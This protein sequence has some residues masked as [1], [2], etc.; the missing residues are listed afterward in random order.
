MAF[1]LHRCWVVWVG[2]DVPGTPPGPSS[3]PLLANH[4]FTNTRSEHDL[5][6]RF[7]ATYDDVFAAPT[8]LPPA[9]ACDHRIHLKPTTEPVAVHLY[10]YPSYRRT[11]WRHSV[12]PCCSRALSGPVPL[13]FRRQ[14]CLSRSRMPHGGSVSTIRHS[15]RLQSKTSFPYPWWSCSTNSTVPASSPGWICARVITKCASIRRTWPRR[16]SRLTMGIL[17]FWSC[18][19]GCIMLRGCSRRS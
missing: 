5:L 2:V 10:R 7:L 8:G 1:H 11:N 6:E 13:P 17:S 4:F 15:P 16:R 12:R 19:L 18:P 14:C 9:H 3:E